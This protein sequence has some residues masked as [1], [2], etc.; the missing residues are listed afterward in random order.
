[1]HYPAEKT[2]EVSSKSDQALGIQLSAFNL[3]A[4]SRRSKGFVTVESLYQCSKVFE[5]K[6]PFPQGYRLSARQ[7]RAM[8]EPYRNQPV[9]SF[10]LYNQ[11]WPLTPKRAFYNWVYCQILSRNIAL[12]EQLDTYS[13][14][15]D[16]EFNPKRS[17][18][19]QAYAIA[20]FRSLQQRGLLKTALASREAFLEVHPPDLETAPSL[21]AAGLHKRQEALRKTK[22]KPRAGRGMQPDLPQLPMS[23]IEQVLPEP[24]DPD[25]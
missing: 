17:I 6:G 25:L 23:L 2:L 9:K 13:S 11:I 10:R 3:G 15:T 14:F 22:R 7:A 18:N 20:L 4:Q 1:M 8:L 5:A 16:I 21:P 12:M 24:D 19:C